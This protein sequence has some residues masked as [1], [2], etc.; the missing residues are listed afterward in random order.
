MSFI[1]DR[2]SFIFSFTVSFLT[3]NFKSLHSYSGLETS[4]TLDLYIQFTSENIAY[5]VSVQTLLSISLKIEAKRLKFQISCLK[6]QVF[7]AFE[8]FNCLK[9]EIFESF[10]C[11]IQVIFDSYYC[12][13]LNSSPKNRV[14]L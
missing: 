11:H 14:S 9:I 4:I 8:F 1:P 2:V 7:Y 3:N 6:I 13:F 12:Y 10:F 5:L